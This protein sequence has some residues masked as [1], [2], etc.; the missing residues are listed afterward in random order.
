MTVEE[1]VSTLSQ[2]SNVAEQKLWYQKNKRLILSLLAGLSHIEF[3]DALSNIKFVMLHG[4][5]GVFEQ[6]AKRFIKVEREKELRERLKDHFDGVEVEFMRDD[7]GRILALET[8]IA[9]LLSK[10][11]HFRLCYDEFSNQI[12][13]EVYGDYKLPWN[14]E[15]DSD[16]IEVKYQQK[17]LVKDTNKIRYYKANAP[18][19]MASLRQHV[20]KFFGFY[21]RVD[22]LK[23]ALLVSAVHN[24]IN[25]YKEQFDYGL[26][27]YDCVDRMDFL[28]RFAGAENREWAR[29]VGLQIFLGL[30]ARCY[31]PGYDFRGV[32]VF[33][34]PENSGKSWLCRALAFHTD[35]FTQFFFTKNTEGYEVAR[36]IA[37]NAVVE[38]TEL[39]NLKS[40]A[41]E[42]IKA[43]LSSTFDVNR[44]MHKDFVEKLKRVGIFII[45]TNE[46]DG[47]LPNHNTDTPEN[48]RFMPIWLGA[49]VIDIAGI[50]S[51]LPQLF[52]QAKYLWDMGIRP[53]LTE[54]EMQFQR[55]M[56]YTRETKP[57]MY[58]I[59]LAELKLMRVQM[60]ASIDPGFTI[61]EVLRR[62]EEA[63]WYNP[64][65]VSQYKKSIG[66]VCKKYFRCENEVQRI[67][68][69]FQVDGK[70][71]SRKWRYKGNVPFDDFIASLEEE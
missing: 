10:S 39:G 8:N 36:Q 27:E 7:K 42:Y 14:H 65:N 49:K 50:Q 5:K 54:A 34:G 32:P 57:E 71:L 24:K 11:K 18:Y 44:R 35:F 3:E 33:E 9:E 52:A 68:K 61:D 41:N 62:N 48:T 12:Y 26:P 20:I 17:H 60:M 28:Y 59:M 2:I 46:R 53:H 19:Q 38:L 30:M 64:Q 23:D 45:T 43:F 29:I 69:E 67:P 55:D 25:I 37:G 31:E 58:Y 13:Y 40:K 47:Y 4:L 66:Q 21:V 56:V 70:E 6:E 51:E 22:E 63:R 15:L 1:I 16:W